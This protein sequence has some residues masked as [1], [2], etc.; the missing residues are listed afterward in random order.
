MSKNS[1]RRAK[2]ELVYL[3][4]SD[5][6]LETINKKSRKEAT[7]PTSHPLDH[8]PDSKGVT[9]YYR[10]IE[11]GDDKEVEW[12]RKLGGMLKREIGEA[13]HRGKFGLADIATQALRCCR[14]E[15]D[16]CAYAGELSSL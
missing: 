15:L 16:Y 1:E 11:I 9:D 2:Y 8:T 4:K 7:A 10:L 12:R 5:G 14:P 3:Q 13:E 6:K